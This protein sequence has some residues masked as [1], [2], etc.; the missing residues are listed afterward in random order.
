VRTHPLNRAQRIVI[1]VGLGAALFVFGQWLTALGSHLPYGW[2][3]YAPLSKEFGP[4]GLHPW[5]RLVIWLILIAIWAVTSAV[6][7]RSEIGNQVGE[8]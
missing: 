3:G 5:V 6:L 4:D 2:V 1:V 8:D 7:L